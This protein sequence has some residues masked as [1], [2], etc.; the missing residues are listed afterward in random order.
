M[1]DKKLAFLDLFWEDILYTKILPLLSLKDLFLMRRVSKQFK[2]LI[3]S[4]FGQMKVLNI[5]LFSQIANHI[6]VKDDDYYIKTA[7]SILFST[8]PLKII[9]TE[10]WNKLFYG[11]PVIMKRVVEQLNAAELKCWLV[12]QQHCTSLQV[13][14]MANCDWLTDDLLVPLLQNNDSIT[15]LILNNCLN[16][17]SICLQPAMI[18]SKNLKT[19]NLANCHWMTIGC[20]HALTLH[21]H[22]LEE[23]D[24]SGC[25]LISRDSLNNFLMLSPKIK[26]LNLSRL[27]CVNDM[28]LSLLARCAKQ[29]ETLNISDC[30][31]VTGYGM[32][33]LIEYC[34]N[35]ESVSCANCPLVHNNLKIPASKNVRLIPPHPN[36]P[37][38]ILCRVNV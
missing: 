18:K 9:F 20:L 16:L 38:V 14:M 33:L 27:E 22:G 29:L 25:N 15:K 12:V 4:Y 30:V 17:S 1:E 13:V 32:S 7:R 5:S 11:E 21:Q 6:A 36:I 10:P 34:H 2:L 23:V 8:R 24:F 28:T 3:D 37:K 19:L 31:T 35:L 26:V